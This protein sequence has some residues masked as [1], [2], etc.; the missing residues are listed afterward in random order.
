MTPRQ[1]K[2]FRL[3]RSISNYFRSIWA[4][5]GR[6]RYQTPLNH[7]GTTSYEVTFTPPP[8]LLKLQWT[9]AS[10]WFLDCLGPYLTILGQFGT[11]L[12]DLGN[13]MPIDHRGNTSYEVTF[14]PPPALLKLQWPPR[15]QMIFRL[16]RSLFN[17]FRPVWDIFGQF[18]ASNANRSP[19]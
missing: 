17:Y 16:F 5:F 11:F 14:T 7:C 9:P 12:E 18:G 8:A 1:H 6:F 10:T 19:R 13:Q 4:I 3:F 2:I 15:Q